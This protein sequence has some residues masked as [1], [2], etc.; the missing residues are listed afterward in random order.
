MCCGVK[1]IVNSAISCKKLS[2][3]YNRICNI[4]L[5]SLANF[6]SPPGNIMKAFNPL[7]TTASDLQ[8]ALSSGEITSVKIVKS[9][10]GHI[11]NHNDRLRAVLQV[12]PERLLL[13]RATALD[14]EREE[15]SLRGPLHGIPVLV[16]V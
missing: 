7:D 11:E 2:Y 16:K 4:S 15:G 14:K 12:A 5:P 6:G 3:Q 10:L 13:E 1:S 8:S 9:Y